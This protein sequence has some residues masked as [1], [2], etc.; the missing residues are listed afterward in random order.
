MSIDQAAAPAWLGSLDRDTLLRA[1]AEQTGLEDFGDDHFVEPLDKLL[2]AAAAEAQLTEVGFAGL[3]MDT[4]RLLSN[5]LLHQADL[6]RHPEIADE[7]VSDPIVIV[8]LP[9]TGTTKLQRMLAADAGL[10]ALPLW[11]ALS[12]APIRGSEGVTPDPRIAV[13]HEQT[14]LLLDLFPGF[15]AAHPMQAEAPEEEM[16]LLQMTFE[17]PGNGL[18]FRIPGYVDWVEDRRRSYPYEYLRDLLRYLQ[19]QD[20]GRRERPWVLKS[21]AHLGRPDRLIEAFPGALVVHCH[22]D[23]A[24][25]VPSLCRLIEHI[26]LSRGIAANDLNE[27][28]EHML[29]Y[30][31]H[32]WDA[33]LDARAGLPGDQIVDL[34]YKRI[35]LATPAVIAELYDMRGMDLSTDAKQAMAD[36][37][38]DNPQDRFGKHEYTLERYGLTRDRVH[39]AF[40]GYLEHFPFVVEDVV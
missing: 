30:C 14:Q 12:P 37:E 6:T 23:P 17:S 16:L 9:R 40:S 26:R 1:A 22:R 31:L 32:E 24:E 20:G 34:H 38:R 19:W 15:M 5:R 11:R 28:G 8:G 18:F 13:A 29:Q 33:N 39:D 2:E 36:W 27:L 7:D 4:V 25:A 21:P 10:Q 3:S 35:V